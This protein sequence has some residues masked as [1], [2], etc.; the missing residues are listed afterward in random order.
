MHTHFKVN[1]KRLQL[2]E[3]IFFTVLRDEMMLSFTK[4]SKI[5][6]DGWIRS[7][8]KEEQFGQI[9]S[10]SK[11][12]LKNCWKRELKQSS[13]VW[14]C[15][16]RER[17]DEKHVNKI[18]RNWKT[19]FPSTIESTF[20]R[21]QAGPIF[22]LMRRQFKSFNFLEWNRRERKNYHKHISLN[23]LIH[24]NKFPILVYVVDLIARSA[25][26]TVGGEPA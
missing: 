4:K 1:L 17:R 9:G 12:M 24:Q 18:I 2:L 26:C 21:H 5:F 3:K 7:R 22:F 15:S 6:D 25:K 8:K 16:T 20:H 14:N 19:N 10:T 23:W 11:K 13:S